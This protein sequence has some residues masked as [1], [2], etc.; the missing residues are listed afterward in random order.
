M[1]RRRRRRRRQLFR[2]HAKSV[3]TGFAFS[4][5][6]AFS[7]LPKR[8]LGPRPKTRFRPKTQKKP[9]GAREALRAGPFSRH[10]GRF[11][12]PRPLHKRSLYYLVMT[13]GFPHERIKPVTS[14]Q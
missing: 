1:S 5:Q 8:A 9:N 14:N 6:N 7:A 11:K 2:D 4:A 13:D 10:R 12:N 3:C